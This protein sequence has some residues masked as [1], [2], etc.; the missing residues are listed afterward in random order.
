M[1]KTYTRT[2][3]IVAC[4]GAIVACLLTVPAEAAP[5]R[6]IRKF[7]ATPRG[8]LDLLTWLE[9]SDC[10]A[11]AIVARGADARPIEALIAGSVELRW[12]SVDRPPTPEA[13]AAMLA[14]ELQQHPH[15]GAVVAPPDG[16]NVVQKFRSYRSTL[17]RQRREDAALL[18]ELQEDWGNAVDPLPR[19]IQ[20]K[21]HD[22]AGHIKFLDDTI[23]RMN[24]LLES[25][26][27]TFE[28]G[29]V[30]D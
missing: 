10:Q 29:L 9:E 22:T 20:N 23:R 27:T 12:L 11:A 24:E 26:L 30:A 4:H 28:K 25:E 21:L 8:M 19:K 15:E 13:H 3:G 18:K 5:Q 2:A 6:Q 16:S 7:E 17:L 14:F 1:E